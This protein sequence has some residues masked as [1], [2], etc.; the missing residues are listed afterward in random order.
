MTKRTIVSMG[1]LG[2]GVVGL[3]LAASIGSLEAAPVVAPV[4]TVVVNP[5]DNPAN[6]K[7]QGVVR[8]VDP[9]TAFQFQNPQE[10]GVDGHLAFSIGEPEGAFRVENVNGLITINAGQPLLA[11][12]RVVNSMENGGFYHFKYL[13][14]QLTASTNGSDYYTFNADIGLYALPGARIELIANAIGF[15]ESPMGAIVTVSGRQ[16]LQ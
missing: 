5:F 8:I 4:Q 1:I 7:V 15:S 16:Q 9:G 2:A 10:E 13:P 12:I 14:L 3:V 11:V 6:V